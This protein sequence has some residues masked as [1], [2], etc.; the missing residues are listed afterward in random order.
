MTNAYF[1]KL[2]F[3]EATTGASCF[4][5][6]ELLLSQQINKVVNY[7]FAEDYEAFEVGLR[8]IFKSIH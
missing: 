1:S 7:I 6:V 4:E 5:S 8:T 2:H 3:S